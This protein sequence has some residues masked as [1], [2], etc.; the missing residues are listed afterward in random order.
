MRFYQLADIE[1]YTLAD[2]DNQSNVYIYQ[3]STCI[4]AK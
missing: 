3:N 4:L 2:T 1:I